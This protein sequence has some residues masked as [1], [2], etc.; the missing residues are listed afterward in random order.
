MANLIS[1]TEYAK[2]HGKDPGNIR[3]HLASGRMEGQKIGNQWVVVEDAVYPKDRRE[4]SG[5]YRNW[6]RAVALH[7]NKPLMKILHAMTNDLREIY[8][9]SLQSVSVYGSY[10]RGTQTDESDVDIALM[11]K[12]SPSREETDA[13][14]RRVSAYELEYGKVLSALEIEADKYAAWKTTIPFYKN[15]EK[16]GVPIWKTG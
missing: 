9:D 6:R 5:H 11:L 15:I 2:L 8:G 4:K 13:M 10:A 1:V 3:R 14:I 16:E 7:S 12:S